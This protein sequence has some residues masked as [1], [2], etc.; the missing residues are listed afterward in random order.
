MKYEIL[1]AP[2][3]LIDSKDDT[4]RI[5]T[6]ADCEALE[7]S[8]KA[9]GLIHPPLLIAEASEF[10]IVSGF[11][12]IAACQNIGLSD[13]PAMVAGTPLSGLE[14][15]K[16]AIA[17][18]ASQRQLNWVETARGI[19]LLSRFLGDHNQLAIV[20]SRLGLPCDSPVII[21]KMKKINGMSKTLQEGLI[22]GRISLPVALELEALD[23]A[24][25]DLLSG[26]F[27]RLSFS[28][29]K[30]REIL[31]LSVEISL[32]DDVSVLHVLEKTGIQEALE[33]KESDRG[34]VARAFRRLLRKTRYPAI[35]KAEELFSDYIKSLKLPGGAK[36]IPPKDF[37]GNTYIIQLQFKNVDELLAH[38]KT[39][40]K[41]LQHPST[42]LMTA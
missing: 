26:I 42:K 9:V 36:L 13:I 29:S 4:F 11:R 20:A 8:I 40:E 30:Q 6:Q 15:A 23:A 1:S 22:S 37:E 17:E 41:I 33:A 5:T 39:L 3:H 21:E 10:K 32:R 7:R 16:M 35:T 14:Y 19:H 38:Q 24:T 28:L 34:Q 18:N 12:R 25:G 27:Q 2:L 31:S